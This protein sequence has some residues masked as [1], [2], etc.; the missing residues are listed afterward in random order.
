M[1][2]LAIDCSTKVTSL[3]LVDGEKILGEI[4]LELGRLQSSKLPLLTEELLQKAGLKLKDIT[5]IGAGRGPGYYTGIRT[6]IA[7]AAALATALDVMIVPL[8]TTE[9]FVFDLR[10]LKQPLAPVIRARHDSVYS[11]L[12]Y[13][14]GEGLKTEIPP[15]FL[16]ADELAYVLKRHPSTIIVGDDAL[17]YEYIRN[18]PNEFVHRMSGFGSTAA[19]MAEMRRKLAIAPRT[20]RGL[21]LR[22]PD[23]GPQKRNS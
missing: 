20:L 2:T 3:G 21:Y 10:T 5:L 16:K 18:L 11:A 15:S 23:I 9:I 7:F 4:N 19:I 1:A 14:D 6:G 12:Y 22:D 17:K 8:D 13:S